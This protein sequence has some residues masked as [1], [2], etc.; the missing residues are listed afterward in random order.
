MGTLD[1]SENDP[2]ITNAV[3]LA[4]KRTV[5]AVTRSN[6]MNIGNATVIAV[7][8]TWQIALRIAA[9]VFGA[10]TVLGAVLWVVTARKKKTA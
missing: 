2:A 6:A 5:Y 9:G 1:G 10:L 4:L 7:T 3:H 8:P